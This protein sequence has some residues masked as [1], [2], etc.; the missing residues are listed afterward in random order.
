V[1]VGLI[2]L[3]FLLIY[4]GMLSS[5]D[6]SGGWFDKEVLR[7]I[8]EQGGVGDTQ[9]VTSHNPMESGFRSTT[10]PVASPAP[11]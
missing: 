9:P 6:L 5:F 4:W 8:Q 2:V 3:V 11:G 1:P 7:T 10:N